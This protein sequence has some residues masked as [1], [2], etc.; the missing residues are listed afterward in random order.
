[1]A[2][3][4]EGEQAVA[5]KLADRELAAAAYVVFHDVPAENGKKKWN[6][7]HVVVGPGVV[8]VL[9]TKAKPR[10]TATRQQEE[11]VV[12][13][14]G[15]ALQY[16]YWVDWDAVG[17]ARRNVDW[18]AEQVKEFAPEG[19]L[20]QPVLVVPGWYVE[21]KGNYPVKAMNAAYLVGYLCGSNVFTQRRIYGASW[22]SW[23][24][25]VGGW[26]F[27]KRVRVK[28]LHFHLGSH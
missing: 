5:E 4:F 18:V 13:F 23:M 6:V 20:V 1:M 12:V 10:R 15:K 19:I 3:R 11:H 22:R 24:S 21:C 28:G 25:C 2:I 27:D 17:E 16:P 8:F 14:D 26:S 7:D 9:E